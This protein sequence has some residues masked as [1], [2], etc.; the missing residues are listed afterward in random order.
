VNA[1]AYYH[2]LLDDVEAEALVTS[3]D[4]TFREIDIN[5]CYVRGT[6]FM[7]G[8]YVLHI[9]EYAITEPEPPTRIKYRY[10]LLDASGSIVRRW[11]NAPHHRDLPSFPYHY[12]DEH[13]IAHSSAPTSVPDALREFQ[14][15]LRAM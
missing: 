13:G 1:H 7:V 6:L 5:E 2:E 14:S 10:Q 8:G 11:D 12:H 3:T 15:I 4:L 9:A